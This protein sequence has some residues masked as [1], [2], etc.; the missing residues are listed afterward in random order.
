[1]RGI[2]T[3]TEELKDE[4]ITVNFNGPDDATNLQAQIEMIEAAVA[5]DVIA[6]SLIHI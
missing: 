3:A 2:D 5:R 1:M 4:G 6:L